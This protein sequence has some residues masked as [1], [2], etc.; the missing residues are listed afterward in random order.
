MSASRNVHRA[1]SD[2]VEDIVAVLRL[3]HAESVYAQVALNPAKLTAFVK[4]AI[5]HPEH[6]CLL[7][8]GSSG[9]IFGVFI[10]Y[11]NSYFFSDEKAARDLITYVR[12][13]KRGSMAAYR[14]WKGFQ[15]WAI[16]KG[17]P[18]IWYGTSSGINPSRSRAFY[19][20]L[21]FTEVGSIF[22][23]PAE[24]N[25]ADELPRRRRPAE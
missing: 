1:T 22:W 20:K 25:S 11:I 18:R 14:L 7:Y 8:K 12:P 15:E 2:E 4:V 3:M 21:G 5:S 16:S 6:V 19:T 24:P 9:E 13:E 17:A 23:M 10:G